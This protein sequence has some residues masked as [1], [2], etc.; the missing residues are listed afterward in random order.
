MHDA[1]RWARIDTEL[2]D[3]P[4]AHLPIGVESVGL[5][6][7]A[8]LGQHQL[9]CQALVERV[10]LQSRSELAEQI[11]V[12]SGA[13]RGVVAIQRDRKPLHL[14]GIPK[15]VEPWRVERRERLTSP[16]R[17][18]RVEQ[19]RGGGRVRRRAGLGGHVAESVHVDRQRIGRQHV[20]ARLPDDLHVAGVGEQLAQPRQ[21]AGQRVACPV[22]SVVRPHPVDQLV[23]R[24]RSVHVD[25]QRRQHTPLAGVA[26]VQPLPVEAG[27]DVAE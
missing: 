3:E 11:G 27:L 15:V 26:D 10:G 2:V 8:V 21:V 18:R 16:Q 1:K 20:A 13:Q 23:R 22:R 5:P 7:A 19:R 24:N 9:P 12:P 4:F 25:Q 17:Q 6:A 14:K